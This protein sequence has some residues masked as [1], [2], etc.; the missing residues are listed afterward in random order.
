MYDSDLAK[1]V[2]AGYMK[3]AEKSKAYTSYCP[4]LEGAKKNSE[5]SS[6]YAGSAQKKTYFEAVIDRPSQTN[7]NNSYSGKDS[8]SRNSSSNPE[9]QQNLLNGNKML[10]ELMNYSR[11]TYRN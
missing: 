4:S 7:F 3:S 9:Y 8:S 6:R 1:D 2:L 10:L 5:T 11:Q